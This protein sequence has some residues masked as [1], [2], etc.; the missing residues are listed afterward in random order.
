ML[1]KT[2]RL[3]S[4]DGFK[5]C[6]HTAR[7]VTTTTLGQRI[8]QAREA[9]GLSQADLASRF[10]IRVQSISQW[11]NDKTTPSRRLID[12]ASFLRVRLG[13]L[14]NGQGPMRDY[15]D[16]DPPGS[17]LRAAEAAVEQRFMTAMGLRFRAVREH[18]RLTIDEAAEALGIPADR[19]A[20]FEAGT[21]AMPHYLLA[22]FAIITGCDPGWLVTG[23][24]KKA[25]EP[26]SKT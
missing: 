5:A 12:L 3:S 13:W 26:S 16:A 19:Y 25:P 18:R 7:M 8:R 14:A 9:A 2:S 23:R 15:D 22:R 20:S 1:D 17:A 6:L 10:D 24:V 11:E 4:G 21:E